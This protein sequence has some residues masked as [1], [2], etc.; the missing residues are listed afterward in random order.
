MTCLKALSATNDG[1]SADV[2]SAIGV[3]TAWAAAHPRSPVVM[4]VSLGV[5]ASRWFTALD[6]AI[7]GAYHAGVLPVISAGNAGRDACAFTPARA[8]HALTVA[9]LDG[10][11]GEGWLARGA[12][13]P[14]ATAAAAARGWGPGGS[15]AAAAV[16]RPATVAGAAVVPAAAAAGAAWTPPTGGAPP[17]P[18]RPPFSA[19]SA[20]RLAPFSNRGRCVSLA[21]PGVDIW[22][23]H[24]AGDDAYAMAS[25]TSM[26]APHVSGLAALVWAENPTASVRAVR[27]ALLEGS[28]PVGGGGGVRSVGLGGGGECV[29]AQ[30]EGGVTRWLRDVMG[31]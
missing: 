17:L 2:I 8:A 9:A 24:N 22:S 15:V 13:R 27:A 20:P 28:V 12:V 1:S 7:N 10:G 26:A 25:G 6:G 31:W 18:P 23:A 29:V 11:G 14:N 4:S 16:R 30:S 5:A 19:R 21:A 3:V